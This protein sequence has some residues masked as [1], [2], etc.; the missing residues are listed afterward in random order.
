[1]RRCLTILAIAAMSTLAIASPAMA[2]TLDGDCD[3]AAVSGDS[4][5]ADGSALDSKTVATATESDPFKVDLSGSV[6]W[7]ASSKVPLVDHTW[8]IGLVIGGTKA[9]F[10]SGGDP[11]TAETQ[12]STGEVSIAD[13]LGE[14]QNSMME[15][16]IGEL[17][18][19]L[20]AWGRIE[21]ADGTFCDGTA[22]VEIDGSFGAIGL[23]GVG[24][25]AAGGAM[26]VGAGVRKKSG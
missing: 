16:V 14:I 19:K 13:R 18:G 7:D 12:T 26:L 1:M 24:L 5:R 2:G 3:A 17:N 6:G 21:A 8:G 11:N 22:W 10:F 20:E 23:L 15:W 4:F 9:Q 25:A